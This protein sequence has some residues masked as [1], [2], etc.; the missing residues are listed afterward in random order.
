MEPTI[1]KIKKGKERIR[2]FSTSAI[3][4]ILQKHAF[5]RATNEILEEIFEGRNAKNL[6]YGTE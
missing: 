5:K 4:M 2:Q 1:N 6:C 3:K